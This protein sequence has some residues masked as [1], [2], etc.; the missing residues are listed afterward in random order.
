[1]KLSLQ[2]RYSLAV[3]GILSAI[4]AFMGIAHLY[5][6]RILI[7]ASTLATAKTVVDA[8]YQ[9]EKR[10]SEN[11]AEFLASILADPVSHSRHKAVANLIAAAAG[12]PG[13]VYVEV[14]DADG[15]VI[16]RAARGSKSDAS[17]PARTAIGP[18]VNSRENHSSQMALAPSN[19]GV[20]LRADVSTLHVTAPILGPGRQ[21]G[22]VTVGT[23]L[24]SKLTDVAKFGGYMDA[25]A[26][27]TMR[28]FLV[29]Y[30]GIAVMI[31]VIGLGIGIIMVR[32]IAHPIQALGR[33]MRRIGTG[34][35][36]QPPP[37]ERDDEL[38]DLAQELSHM[39]QNLKKASKVSKLATLG[40][41][42]VG[43][44]HELNQPLN[45]IRL[46]AENV[47]LSQ[48]GDGEDSEFTGS[49]LRLISDQAAK[50]GDL[51][52]RM[53]VVGRT[54][55]SRS[56]LDARESVH[57]AVSLLISQCEDQGIAV[58]VDMPEEPA[59]VLGRRD[60]LAQVVI[61]LIANARDAIL[62]KAEDRVNVSSA[63]QGR[64]S[65]RMETT[66]EQ[67]TIE[68]ADN[69]GGI[70]PDALQ[71]IFDPFFT[72]KE[73]TKGTG[74]GLSISLGIIDAMGGQID[75]ANTESGAVFTVQLPRASA[76]AGVGPVSG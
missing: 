43:V 42:S 39:S 28:S 68:V 15:R 19:G 52:Q 7:N 48:K 2:V 54:E 8:L 73:V 53:C 26:T 22:T 23:S 47:L 57:D 14:R 3:V 13:V 5:G 35:Y 46:A 51:I 58:N 18:H 74:L 17:Q 6:F 55:S 60:E 21:L 66:A 16:G 32:E 64:I 65:V 50:M 62:G 72:T 9:E 10:Q 37:F 49:K 41:L 70:A 31:A 38:G 34:N 76:Q 44:A 36:D 67:V 61:N 1:M 27:K 4:V 63:H 20:V 45:T 71:R 40:E 25:V 59:I 30:T 75:A 12:R 29:L 11:H 56:P 33:Y 69:G 24:K